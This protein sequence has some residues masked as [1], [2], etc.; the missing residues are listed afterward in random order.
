ML[1]LAQARKRDTNTRAANDDDFFGG[2]RTRTKYLYDVAGHITRITHPDNNYF[3]YARNAVGALDQ[4]NLNAS[5]PLL[6][7]TLDAQGRLSQFNRWRTS[8]GDWSAQNSIGYDSVSRVA[9]LATDVNGSISDTTTN[10]TYNPANQIAS[11]TRTNDAYAWNGQVNANLTY[12]SD[13]LNR[14]TGAS[15]TYDAN[16]N[17][18]SDS[19]NTFVYD[20]ENRPGHAHRLGQRNVALRSARAAV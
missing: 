20:V 11:A 6:K 14:Y 15:F 18:T 10:F 12:T 13:G 3:T 19:A 1:A 9:S 8:S 17:L 4:I 5:A 7:P 16:G 2:P